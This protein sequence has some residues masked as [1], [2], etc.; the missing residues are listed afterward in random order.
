MKPSEL[1]EQFGKR[2]DTRTTVHCDYRDIEWVIDQAFKTE[3]HKHGYE[4]PCLEEIGQTTMSVKVDSSGKYCLE[5]R[6]FD[7]LK[8]GKWPNFSTSA[9]LN[10]LCARGIIPVG[11]Y[12]IDVTW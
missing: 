4:L 8:A 7:M 3:K 11:E 1:K 5:E 12:I 9:F 10:T 6:H 2:L